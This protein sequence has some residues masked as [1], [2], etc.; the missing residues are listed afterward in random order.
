METASTKTSTDLA[1]VEID[2][3]SQA[4]SS[5]KT[6]RY[7]GSIKCPLCS[8]IIPVSH[9]STPRS[10]GC[11]GKPWWNTSNFDSHLTHKHCF[12][13]DYIL[14]SNNVKISKFF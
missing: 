2:T 9:S 7:V 13:G 8:K 4:S 1:T 6:V 3:S 14:S 5:D 11:S 12:G 10:N